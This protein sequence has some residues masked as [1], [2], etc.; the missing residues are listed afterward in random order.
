M[1]MLCPFQCSIP[2]SCENWSQFLWM[3]ATLT[4]EN[5]ANLCSD[6]KLCSTAA[7]TAEE[8]QRGCIR[9]LFPLAKKNCDKTFW[10]ENKTKNFLFAYILE[11]CSV[12]SLRAM[13]CLERHVLPSPVGPKQWCLDLLSLRTLSLHN[14]L[15]WWPCLQ[16]Y[17]LWPLCFVALRRAAGNGASYHLPMGTGIS[18]CEHMTEH[19]TSA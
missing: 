2:S 4:G 13:S 12:S 9:D 11:K 5:G 16:T 15:C 10:R 18:L 1:P 19:M 17:S 6:P 3:L 8:N 14:Q 7:T